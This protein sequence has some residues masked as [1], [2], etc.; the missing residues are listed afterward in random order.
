MKSYS[1]LAIAIFLLSSS[2]GH[3][4]PQNNAAENQGSPV[5]P[6][7]ASEVRTMF[8]IVA[9]LTDSVNARK[10]KVGDKVKAE[11]TQD[12]VAKG[13]ILIPVES[14]LIGHVTE[15]QARTDRDHPS[16]LGIV[17]DKIVFKHHHELE[18]TGILRRLAAPLPSRSR[19]DEPD[20]MMPPSMLG[21]GHGGNA[22]PMGGS[23]SRTNVNSNTTASSSLPAGAPVY[24]DGTPGSNVGN[25]SG[26]DLR[27][28]SSGRANIPPEAVPRL[29]VGMPQG[30]TGMKD[31]DLSPGPTGPVIVSSVRD[32]K[33]ET[34]TQV[35]LVAT[36]PHFAK[37]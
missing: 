19:V 1:L 22:G 5:V 12:V 37:Q 7:T 21:I 16:R 24:V 15:A 6:A 29:S 17:F 9:E 14:R 33:L 30:I 36:D 31:L 13:R 18:I 10:L 11:V 32:V 23:P 27:R 8:F 4:Q 3:T 26:G 34:G 35:L 2:V 25:S 28:A 20:Q